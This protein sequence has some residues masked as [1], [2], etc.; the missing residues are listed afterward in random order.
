VR[1]TLALAVVLVVHA[2]VASASRFVDYV[3]IEANEGGSS[4]GHT[5]IRFGD[6]TYHFQHE[7]PGVLRL[8]RDDW[9]QFRYAYGVLQNRT[10]H[11]SHV[12]VPDADYARL[13]QRF[14]ERFLT[15]RKVF[16][17]QAAL[18]DDRRLLA[19][20]L[21]RR[22]GDERGAVP[23]P[24]AGFF[25]PADGGAAPSAA[26]LALREQ[27]ERTHGPHAIRQRRDDIRAQ[28]ARLTPARFPGPTADLPAEG[29]P[30]FAYPFSSRYRDLLTAEIA[31]DVLD[32][33][34]S[35]RPGSR[36]SPTGTDFDLDAAERAQLA[37]YADRLTDELTRLLRSN[38]PDW[39]F[40]FLV[41]LA[42]LE[43]LRASVASGRLLLLDAFPPEA[44]T[45][46]RAQVRRHLDA[47][48]GL[49]ADARDEFT[50]ARE[51]LDVGEALDE[52]RFSAIESA[53]N[54]L[55]ELDAA[56]TQDRDLRVSSDAL[57]PSREVLWSE[58]TLPAATEDDL[59][60]RLAETG[61]AEKAFAE[62]LYQ[63]YGYDL[64][65]RNCVSEI[66]RTV[67]AAGTDPG[68]HVDTRWS[69]D[70]IPFVAAH[71]VN[72]TWNVVEQT[73]LPSYRRLRLE[74]MAE[75]ESPLRVRLRES[76]VFT[77]TI[78]HRTADDS[79]FVFFTDDTVALRPALGAVNLAAGLGAAAV[80]VPLLPFDRG[81]TLMSGVRGALFSLPELALVNL[82]K[83]SFA[84]VSPNQRP[85]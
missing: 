79:F 75:H 30:D 48:R 29:Y 37:A 84:Y 20:V 18:R 7:S 17:H 21:A 55:L 61:D 49:R 53:G 9:E 54:R 22:R 81:E 45:V 83:G 33:A 46:P 78:Y 76:N 25:F 85:P 14:N 52:Q 27:V 40:A 77:S 63:R 57:V 68:G 28:L 34:L 82:R 26:A 6:E 5:A 42:R 23:V 10:M 32:R 80:G 36:W 73:T 8:R 31:L 58:P 62:R 70:F 64:I 1:L 60:R 65:T 24:G 56:L 41:G 35:L 12:A 13:R 59:T 16:E 4:G 66:F 15:E 39:G 2:A 47:L 72:E 44:E 3:Y 71:T 69:L 11:V 51:R 67:D 19:L 74:D 43:A 38:R 50:H